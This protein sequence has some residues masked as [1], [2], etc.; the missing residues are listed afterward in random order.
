MICLLRKDVFLLAEISLQ[1]M[2][3]ECCCPAF[4]VSLDY[5]PSC[6]CNVKKNPRLN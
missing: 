2:E 3:G 6:I 4:F 5:L 1:S